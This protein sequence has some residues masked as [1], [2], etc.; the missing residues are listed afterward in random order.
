MTLRKMFATTIMGAAALGLMNSCSKNSSDDGGGTTSALTIS[1]TVATSLLAQS[2]VGAFATAVTD[3]QLYAICLALPPAIGSSDV[4][5]DGSFTVS[6]SCPAG[7]LVSALF[8][9]KTSLDTV[10]QIYFT[11]SSKT[12]LDGATSKKSSIALS[13]SVSFG[14]ISLANGEV[15]IP[16]SQVT[17]TAG[18]SGVAD[19]LKANC[20]NI[21]D[22]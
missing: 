17:S 22:S 15:T 4:A 1:G 11:D 18:G 12:G 7:S 9:D 10:G 20:R 21:M 14:N 8:R 6:L 2:K 13:G 5:A 16:V 19:P 3:L